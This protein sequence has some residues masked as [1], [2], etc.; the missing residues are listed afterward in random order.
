VG[1]SIAT[2]DQPMITEDL[3]QVINPQIVRSL[4]RYSCQ[5]NLDD[6]DHLFHLHGH[7]P[8]MYVCPFSYLLVLSLMPPNL[9][10]ALVSVDISVKH[11]ITRTPYDPARYSSLPIPT[12]FFV[13]S[14]TTVSSTVPSFPSAINEI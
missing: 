6:G 8:W 3:I 14:W 9:E 7:R 12:W 13:S 4:H 11:S 2:G 1:L 10:W 5:D